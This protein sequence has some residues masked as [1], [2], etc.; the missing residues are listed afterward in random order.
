MGQ[1]TV[2]GVQLVFTDKVPI[3]KI[4]H[5]RYDH[6]VPQGGN[7]RGDPRGGGHHSHRRLPLCH[8]GSPHSPISLYICQVK[9]EYCKNHAKVSRKYGK[10]NQAIVS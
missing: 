7:E 9:L 6:L 8:A 5:G 10:I 2:E 1:I 3:L 4:E